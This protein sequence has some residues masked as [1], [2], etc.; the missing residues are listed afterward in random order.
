MSREAS[1]RVEFVLLRV[2]RGFRSRKEVVASLTA[3]QEKEGDESEKTDQSWKCWLQCFVLH[4]E[5][6]CRHRACTRCYSSD[7]AAASYYFISGSA[8]EW[9]F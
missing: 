7:H 6:S 4:Q 2:W 5:K 9:L 8:S 1:S 3:H